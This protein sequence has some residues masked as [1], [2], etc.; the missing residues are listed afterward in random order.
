MQTKDREIGFITLCEFLELEEVMKC[1]I[2]Q[3]MET[4]RSTG[5]LEFEEEWQHLMKWYNYRCVP[6]CLIVVS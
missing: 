5:L 2:G 3:Q 4:S 1:L 6:R